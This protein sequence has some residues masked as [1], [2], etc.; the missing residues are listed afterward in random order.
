MSGESESTKT[1]INNGKVSGN[2]IIMSLWQ[3]VRNLKIHYGIKEEYTGIHMVAWSYNKFQEIVGFVIPTFD[4]YVDW[5]IKVT[6]SWFS[7]ITSYITIYVCATILIALSKTDV[8]NYIYEVLIASKS[9]HNMRCTATITIRLMSQPLISSES[10]T[11]THTPQKTLT[12]IL[13]P[14]IFVSQPPQSITI[15]ILHRQPTNN[16][17][18]YIIQL[19]SLITKIDDAL[20]PLFT[21]EIYFNWV[22]FHIV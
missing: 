7:I 22:K 20:W 5:A 16:L 13:S 14:I 18:F 19:L 1:T 21:N 8:T 15:T 2:H 4:A 11:H 12:S 17:L 3:E 6:I 9:H 10:Q